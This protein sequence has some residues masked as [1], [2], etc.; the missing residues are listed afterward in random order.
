M[1]TD[2]NKYMQ[3]AAQEDYLWAISQITE[4]HKIYNRLKDPV[5]LEVSANFMQAAQNA[6]KRLER[7]SPPT[8]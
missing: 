7:L 4:A 1:A 3:E 5:W 8:T 2:I 6:K